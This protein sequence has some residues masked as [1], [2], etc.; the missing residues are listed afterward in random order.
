M[1]G[2]P[3][4]STG[5]GGWRHSDRNERQALSRLALRPSPALLCREG[6][7]VH[8]T[9][10][11][12]TVTVAATAAALLAGLF[13]APATGRPASAHAEQPRRVVED[14]DRGLVAVPSAEGTFLSWRLLGTE[15]AR[16]GES[17][18]FNVYKNGRR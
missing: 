12:R 8:A 9:P 11:R 15:Y 3:E 4:A 5:G 13:A 1:A 17:I 6:A 2:P 18:A 7:L 10:R 14:L 16:H